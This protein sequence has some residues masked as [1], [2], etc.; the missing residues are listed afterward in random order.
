MLLLTWLLEPGD[1]NGS[2]HF[3]TSPA[4]DHMQNSAAG[5]QAPAQTGAGIPCDIL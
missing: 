2:R 4:M 5:V 1:P 3:F